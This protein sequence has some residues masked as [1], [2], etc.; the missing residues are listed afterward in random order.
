MSTPVKQCTH[1]HEVKP[2]DDFS[3]KKCSKDGRASRCKVCNAAALRA[4]RATPQGKKAQYA[5]HQRY[6]ATEHGRAI[7]E[8]YRQSP[9]Y[10]LQRQTPEYKA[11]RAAWL[12][13][14]AGKK[15]VK[16]AQARYHEK[17]RQT[18][19][20]RLKAAAVNAV[21][22]AVRSGL[23]P[24]VTELLCASCGQPAEQYH[25]YLGYEQA[26]HLSVVPLC[27]NCH[28]AVHHP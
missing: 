20:G 18:R 26:F 12:A 13:T 5:S 19:E 17:K 7:T 3:P 24:R 11:K 14:D 4:Y 21:N 25:H 23:L 10:R 2:L 27:K 28:F 22:G 9:E 8:A 15:A 6:Y 16:L 1:C